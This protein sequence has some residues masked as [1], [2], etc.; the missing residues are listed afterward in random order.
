MSP[1][2]YSY[3]E[4]F[5][6]FFPDSEGHIKKKIILKVSDFRSALVQGKML[7]AKG[8]WISEYRIESGVN[9]GGHAFPTQGVL[10]GPILEEFRQNRDQLYITCLEGY[11]EA[12]QKKSLPQPAETP[13]I[14]VT[15][16]GGVGTNEEHNFLLDYYNM[17]SVGWDHR[18]CWCQK[19]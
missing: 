11:K 1:R 4:N 16:Q 12:L 8:L 7:A 6:D 5:G 17:D 10:L 3:I 18:F 19:Q 9:C 13:E 14:K 15:A 2:L